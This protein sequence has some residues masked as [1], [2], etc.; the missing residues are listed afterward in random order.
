[1]RFSAAE[2]WWFGPSGGEYYD[3]ALSSDRLVEGKCGSIVVEMLKDGS[4]R[5]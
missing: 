3:M 2:Y 5:G 1:M 4:Y